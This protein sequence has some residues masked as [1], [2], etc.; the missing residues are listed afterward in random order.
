MIE[1][2]LNDIKAEDLRALI[3]D[4][5][6]EGKTLD[7]KREFPGE[8]EDDKHKFLAE[9]SSFANA[10]GGDMI[11]G[12]DER[13]EEGKKTA[14]A[15]ELKG[16]RAEEIEAARQRL[17]NLTRTAISP[18]VPGL[19]FQPVTVEEGLSVLVLRIPRS[20]AAPH[21]VTLNGSSRFYARTSEGKHQ[22]N[23]HE[24]RAAFLASED[25]PRRMRE[26]R[27]ERLG[28]ILAGEI[29]MGTLPP[30]PKAVIHVLPF[31]SFDREM[32]EPESGG[33]QQAQIPPLGSSGC[34]NFRYTLEGSLCYDM[35]SEADKE[36]YGYTHVY[37]SGIV[38]SVGWWVFIHKSP[39]AR[40]R[41][42]AEEFERVV[43]EWLRNTLNVMK[44]RGISMPI[45]VT[46]SIIE[47]EDLI[48]YRNDHA[49]MF[50]DRLCAGRRVLNLPEAVLEN[51][52][53]SIPSRLKPTF[54][55][56]WRSVNY[57]RSLN[58]TESGE[59]QGDRK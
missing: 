27:L 38:E 53:D 6:P 32:G 30:G 57:P 11:F 29:P 59:W 31:A 9:V 45:A 21:M 19:Q 5:V 55:A 12:M 4:R 13:R 23:V 17:A 54:D 47:A 42:P 3:D 20:F 40:P 34:R 22:L 36:C 1:K 48:M 24:I 16:F 52:E 43:I 44:L 28:S 15:G 37:L 10:S 25:L 14:L 58:Y 50:D 56:L 39:N 51:Y 41:L 7:F 2:P 46:L 49:E 8:K 18:R 26:F 35:R 33:D